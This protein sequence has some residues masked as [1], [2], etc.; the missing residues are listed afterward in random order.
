MVRASAGVV[1]IIGQ[2]AAQT[3]TG[4]A[5]TEPQPDDGSTRGTGGEGQTTE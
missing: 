3:T 5:D 1:A 4:K 2:L